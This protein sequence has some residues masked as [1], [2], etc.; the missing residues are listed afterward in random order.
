MIVSGPTRTWPCSMNLV[1]Y[2]ADEYGLEESGWLRTALTDSAIFDMHMK[3]ARRLRQ[4]A[5]TVSLFSISESLAE[6][7]RMPIS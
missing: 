1:A 3:T 6:E 2:I 4:K 7:L 5:A